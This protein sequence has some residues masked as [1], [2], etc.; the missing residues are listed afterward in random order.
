[1]ALLFGWSLP[2]LLVLAGVVLCV[3]EAF[4]PGA[5][6]IVVGVALLAAGLIGLY[7]PVA[8]SPWAQAVLVLV[9]GAGTLYAYR[10]FAFVG[11]GERSK[12][13]GSEGLVGKKGY[14]TEPV[15]PR[16]G[17]VELDSAGFDSTYAARTVTGEIPEGAR[18]VVTDPGGG[19]VITVEAVD[20]SVEPAD[21][22]DGSDVDEE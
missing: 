11:R 5:H 12:T 15:T 2:F 1:M 19:N 17:H 6:F 22:G 20:E 13:E 10:R 7:V 14:A 3:L 4:A 16:S 21:T 18:V 8:A 9:V